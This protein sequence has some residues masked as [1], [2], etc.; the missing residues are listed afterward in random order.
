VCLVTGHALW[1][2]AIL[3]TECRDSSWGA[4]PAF[5]S[6]ALP[7]GGGASRLALAFDR[8]GRAVDELTNKTLTGRS[9][10]YTLGCVLAVTFVAAAEPFRA[11]LVQ[12]PLI[13]IVV[14][15]LVLVLFRGGGSGGLAGQGHRVGPPLIGNF[16]VMPSLPWAHGW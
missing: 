4:A 10:S 2:E 8:G 6:P 11:H 9:K 5:G 3:T 15:R 16:R 1:A 14:C 13:M 12:R 7:P